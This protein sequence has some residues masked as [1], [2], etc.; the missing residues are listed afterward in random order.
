MLLTCGFF[1]ILAILYELLKAYRRVLAVKIMQQSVVHLSVGRP[2]PDGGDHLS[3]GN[4]E[5]VVQITSP[6]SSSSSRCGQSNS[7]HNS[8]WAAK[9]TNGNVQSVDSEVEESLTGGGRAGGGGGSGAGRS[10]P[11]RPQQP[12][13]SSIDLFSSWS[14][15]FT[16]SHLRSTLLYLLQVMFAYLLML[17]FMLFNVW[18]AGAI[19]A[20][21]AVGHFLISQKAVALQDATNEDS[22]H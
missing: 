1:F 19:L 11:G 20:G 8:S 22:C 18:I 6:G 5:M 4:R 12:Q 10:C 14:E 2:N 16:C 7:A 9:E 13:S 21:A 3:A 15:M 17:A